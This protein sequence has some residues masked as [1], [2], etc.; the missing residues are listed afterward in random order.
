MNPL[1]E[2]TNYT[3][4]TKN[5]LEFVPFMADFGSIEIQL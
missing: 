1:E 2:A 5:R 4:A 3:N